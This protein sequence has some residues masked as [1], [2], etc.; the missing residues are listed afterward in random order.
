MLTKEKVFR[1]MSN[2]NAQEIFDGAKVFDSK[3]TSKIAFNLLTCFRI[4]LRQYNV[5]HINNKSQ[6]YITMMES[7]QCSPP[8]FEQNQI[9]EEQN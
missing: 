4:I 1:T 7:K 9:Q 3:P 2:L 8:R 6:K 5:I